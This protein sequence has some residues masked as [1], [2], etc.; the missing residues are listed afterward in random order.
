MSANQID[1]IAKVLAEDSTIGQQN[2]AQLWDAAHGASSVDELS[3]R[4]D[5]YQSG[6][7]HPRLV[8]NLLVAKSKQLAPPVKEPLD[9]V[10]DAINR[11]GKMDP[12]TLDL[13]ENN[14]HVFA[15]HVQQALSEKS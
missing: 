3:D 12:A 6:S 7:L 11:M 10:V 4:L 8:R 14:P 13:A 9:K 2:R 5:A 1:H 15:A